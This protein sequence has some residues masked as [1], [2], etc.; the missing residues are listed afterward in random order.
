M[1]EQND[2]SIEITLWRYG[3]ISP[4]LHRDANDKSFGNM[5]DLASWQ[6]YVH[7][8]GTHVNLSTETIRKWLYRYLH[9]GL[10]GLNAKTRSDKG[11]HKIPDTICSEMVALREEHSRWT[12]A[13]ILKSLTQNGI[14]NGRKPSRS[15]L[16]RF[17]DAHNLQRDLH[18]YPKL[19]TKPFAFDHFGQLWQADFL[20]GPK[21]FNGRKK[22]K[23]YLHVILDDSSR[24]IVHGGFYL[25]ESAEPLIYDIMGAVRRFGLP[26]RFYT[27]NGPAYA[28]RHLKLLCARNGID[29]V[30]TPPFRPQGRGKVE[31]F[32]R[33]VRDQFLCDKFK[34]ATQINDTFKVWMSSYHETLHS[35]LN[36]SPLQKRLQTRSVCRKIP[37]SIDIEALFRMERRCKVYNDSTIRFKKKR[38]EVPGCLPGSRVTIYYMPWDKT[39]IYYGNEM[40]KARLLDPFTNARRF[41]NPNQ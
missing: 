6:T 18:I 7:P 9:L 12:L 26:Q 4:L 34:T 31:R 16:Y 35:S 30:H 8:N 15:A 40:K 22:Q 19:E 38:Y 20:H 14:W 29:L 37:P 27:D 36:C 24:F 1:T 11:Q 21:L 10:P 32:F 13:R 28:S 17:A 33:T 5:L 3:I 39:C 25:T 23:T 2:K 41:E